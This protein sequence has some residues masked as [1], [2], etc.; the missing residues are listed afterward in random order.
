VVRLERKY[1]IGKK[2]LHFANEPS[3]LQVPSLFHRYSNGLLNN[4]GFQNPRAGQHDDQAHPPITPCKAVDPAS[5]GDPIQRGVYTLIVKHYLACCSRDAIGKETSI[6]VQMAS[7]EFTAKGLMILEKN[8]LEI[9]EP[10]ER[11]STGQGQLPPVQVGSRVTP[12]SLLMKDGRTS[13]PQPI[14]E[15]EL[16][17]LMDRNGIGTDA[18]IAQHISTIQEREYASK[19]AAL[20][21][22]PTALG[23]ALVEGYN[24]MGYQLNKPDLRREM[25]HECNLV[26]NGQKTKDDIVGP[27]L[28]KMRQCFVTATSEAHK[29]DEAVARHFP[30]IGAGN[31]SIVMQ[32][33]FSECGDCH[34]LMS[35]KQVNQQGNN[36]NN[37]NQHPRKLLFCN[38]C[39]KGW[40]LPR[41]Q[42]RPKTEEENG[43]PPLKCAICNFQAIGIGRGDGYEG[44]GYHVCPKCFSDPPQDQEGASN[45]GDFR[46]FSCSHPTCA[47]ASGT[48]G[49]GIEVLSCPFCRGRPSSTTGKV[50]LRKNS[51]GYILGCSNYSGRDR[52]SYTIWLP[53]ESQSVSVPSNDENLCPNCTSAAGQVRK[54]SFVWKPGSV[55]PHLGGSC[56]VCVLCDT[57]FR[58][59][60]RVSLPQPNQVMTNQR[61]RGGGGGGGAR[62]AA[63]SNRNNGPA[64]A[65]R[66][67]N[68]GPA[69]APSNRNNVHGN[70][71]GNACYKCGQTGHYANNCPSNSN[72]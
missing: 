43:G 42:P 22:L 33:N 20:K 52:C 41:G 65:P 69:P 11:W 71:T 31:D 47:L 36:N 50:T 70:S 62:V 46:C 26:A 51:R 9:Y 55:P 15:V 38:T 64:A 24:S 72:R 16:I 53:K 12:A 35:L 29:L 40:S 39:Q 27:I 1:Q 68:N 5:I 48:Q 3:Y 19:D 23:I 58:E 32:A 21:F 18:T 60:M 45:G 10:W 8:W 6:T 2:R 17:S 66:N 56:T 28:A 4:G 67:R 37:G 49:G 7:E 59:D 25:E 30:R 57:A 54:I 44:N 61:R 34:N 63:P 13:A 14:S